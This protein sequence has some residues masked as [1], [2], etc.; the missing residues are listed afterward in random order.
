MCLV[1][2]LVHLAVDVPE[3]LVA[4]HTILLCLVYMYIFLLHL[5]H[6]KMGGGQGNLMSCG[7]VATHQT[8]QTACA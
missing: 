5:M 1:L 4:T 2:L 3:A 7:R 6:V 8:P